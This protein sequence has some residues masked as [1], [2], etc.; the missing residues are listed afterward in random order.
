MLFGSYQGVPSGCSLWDWRVYPRYVEDF[1]LDAIKAEGKQ[2]LSY[3]SAQG[4]V[5][6]QCFILDLN[7]NRGDPVNLI[8]FPTADPTN[9]VH[10]EYLTLQAEKGIVKYLCTPTQPNRIYQIKSV[11]RNANGYWTTL[12]LID[13]GE[14]GNPTGMSVSPEMLY[15]S[16]NAEFWEYSFKK[17]V[18]GLTVLP[19]GFKSSAWLSNIYPST[20]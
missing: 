6:P 5:V 9:T 20:I 11:T 3:N 8:M 18:L 16:S 1:E 14:S 2:S 19:V 10:N 12:E 17:V 7:M 4:P 15:D 13:V